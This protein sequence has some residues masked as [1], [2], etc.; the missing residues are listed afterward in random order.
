[1][2]KKGVLLEIDLPCI[3]HKH[4]LQLG[5]WHK[6]EKKAADEIWE[7]IGG[8]LNDLGMEKGF[9]LVIRTQGS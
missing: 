9:F 5:Q 3:M 2:F 6:C 7:S 1:M 4:K 8:Y